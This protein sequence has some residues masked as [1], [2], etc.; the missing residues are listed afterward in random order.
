MALKD[1]EAG[2]EI[3]SPMAIVI[4]GGLLA[5]TLLNLI[6]ILCL[7]ELVNKRKSIVQ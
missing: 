1:G 2:N 3:Q 7:Y 5:K 4:L 6:V